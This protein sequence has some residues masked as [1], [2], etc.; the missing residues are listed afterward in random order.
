M[1]V[2]DFDSG[3]DPEPPEFP[4]YLPLVFLV[5]PIL[6]LIVLYANVREA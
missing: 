1:A 2:A 4:W 6:L 3:G 5:P